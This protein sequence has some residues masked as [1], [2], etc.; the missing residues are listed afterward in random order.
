MSVTLTITHTR[1]AGTLID[2]TAKGDGTAPTLKANGWRWGRSIG[3]WFVPQSRDRTAKTWKIN[4]T[5]EQLRAAG[6]SVTV[7][8]D[9]TARPTADVVADQ[10][11]R[12][13]ERVAALDAKAE[14]KHRDAAAA[15]ARAETAHAALPPGGEPIKIGH[16]SEHRHRRAIEKSWNALGKAVHAREDAAEA[17][18]RA[19]SAAATTGHRHD[20][21]VT[22]RRIERLSADLRRFERERDGTNLEWRTDPA[23]GKSTLGHWPATG[24]RREQLDAR[25]AELADQIT[26]WQGEIDAAKAAG[27]LIF[28]RS[29]IR[30]GDEVR[31]RHGWY[32]VRRVNAKSVTV[33]SSIG[34]GTG[35]LPYDKI[36][37]VR[38]SEGR[39]VDYTDGVRQE[40]S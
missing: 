28:D 37:A 38:D 7:E 11:T 8:V 29:M 10:D 2:G 33:A 4:A 12:Q 21:G 5:V 14:R 34:S 19:E 35:T 3:T 9:D 18:R 6:F 1:E 39:P 27:I 22:A 40:P 23:T 13:A 30:K 15:D 36:T 24:R 31:T 16:H 26:Y 32:E 25:I 20:P 17:D